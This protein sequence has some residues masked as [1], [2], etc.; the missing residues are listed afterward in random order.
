LPAS[1]NR[2]GRT[3]GEDRRRARE[4]PNNNPRV[5]PEAAADGD[6]TTVHLGALAGA[7]LLIGGLVALCGSIGLGSAVSAAWARLAG[8]AAVA[9]AAA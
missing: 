4:D 9:A 6:G 1:A 8:A 7:L 2:D 3:D 5:S